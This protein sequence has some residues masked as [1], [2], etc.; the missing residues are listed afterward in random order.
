MYAIDF[1]NNV[2]AS[3]SHRRHAVFICAGNL[4]HRGDPCTGGGHLEIFLIQALTVKPGA[5]I[6]YA[7]RRHSIASGIQ[8]QCSAG[9]RRNLIFSCPLGVSAGGT[10]LR[11]NILRITIAAVSGG[12]LHM[13]PSRRAVRSENL[14]L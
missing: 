6:V 9:A 13:Q 8:R 14:D 3:L 1:G 12:G 10:P 2:A 4:R 7:A 11:L 5:E